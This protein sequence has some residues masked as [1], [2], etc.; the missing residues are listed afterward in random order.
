MIHKKVNS[1]L[2]LLD[3]SFHEVLLCLLT[4]DEPLEREHLIPCHCCFVD[5]DL[6]VLVLLD[7]LIIRL[8]Q[9]APK[10]YQNGFFNTVIRLH[11][12][13]FELRRIH[14]AQLLCLSAI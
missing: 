10:R 5:L 4:L 2:V 11:Q 3:L 9:A 12:S 14:S 1:G 6:S 13:L 8:A 7:E